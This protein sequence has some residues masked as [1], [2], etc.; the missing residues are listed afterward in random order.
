MSVSRSSDVAKKLAALQQ[1]FKEQL[2]E[3]VSEIKRLW[4]SFSQN[5]T[6]DAALADVHRMAHSLAGSGGTFG[7]VAVST[8]AKE[9]EQV[10]KSLLNVTELPDEVKQNVE[11]LLIELS[12]TV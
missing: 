8:V 2:P 6:S 3:K 11:C 4:S 9:L 5:T 7:A 12:Q 10:F 1:S